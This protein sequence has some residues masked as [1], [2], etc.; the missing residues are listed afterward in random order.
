[1]HST[2]RNATMVY[3]KTVT[4]NAPAKYVYILT[5]SGTITYEPGD[6]EDDI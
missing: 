4:K 5:I 2:D 1:M 3:N 6:N